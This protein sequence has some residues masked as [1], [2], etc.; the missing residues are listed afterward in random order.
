MLPNKRN[1]MIEENTNEF[2]IS[3]GSNLLAERNRF[4]PRPISAPL[5]SPTI[6]PITANTEL[7]FR[8]VIILGVDSGKYTLIILNVLV[9]L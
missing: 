8:P 7:I 6:A 5:N 2:I 1:P 3:S 4:F 9:A